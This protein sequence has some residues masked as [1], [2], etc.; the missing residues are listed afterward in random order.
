MHYYTYIL[1][2]ESTVMFYCG[3]TDSIDH[4]LVRHN[5]GMVKSTK[6]GIPWKLIGF[7]TFESRSESMALEKKIKGRGIERWMNE[8]ASLLKHLHGVSR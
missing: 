7:V 8:N 3:Q 6:H 4:R 5:D 2:S 1:R